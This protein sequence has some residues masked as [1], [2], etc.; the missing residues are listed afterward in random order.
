MYRAT[1]LNYLDVYEYASIFFLT[2]AHGCMVWAYNEM[3][4]GG[5][6]TSVH[7][8]WDFL[9]YT[10]CMLSKTYFGKQ[11]L[12]STSPGCFRSEDMFALELRS[13]YK[14]WF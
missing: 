11:P 12:H 9:L 4:D 5:R 8:N 6:S 1:I 10:C 7:S 13:V 14:V 3:V 2:G